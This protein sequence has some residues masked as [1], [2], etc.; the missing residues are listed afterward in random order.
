MNSQEIFDKV[1]VHLLTQ[2]R[3]LTGNGG[4]CMYRGDNGTKCAVGCL[5][6]DN[7]YDPSIEGLFMNDRLIGKVPSFRGM[8]EEQ[9]YMLRELQRIHD[10]CI[11][12]LTDQFVNKEIAIEKLNEIAEINDLNTDAIRDLI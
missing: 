4:G 8:T 9:I 6:P 12:E 11:K 1:A 10:Y 5:I 7:E 3:S 2:P